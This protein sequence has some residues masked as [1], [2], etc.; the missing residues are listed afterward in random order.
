MTNILLVLIFRY[1]SGSKITL[2]E[3]SLPAATRGARENWARAKFAHLAQGYFRST[4]M[5]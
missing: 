3:T 1:S 4:V 2:S 5:P